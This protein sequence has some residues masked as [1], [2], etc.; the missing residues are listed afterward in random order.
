M[1]KRNDRDWS[2]RTQAGYICNK[3]IKSSDSLDLIHWKLGGMM[4]RKDHSGRWK[5]K[6]TCNLV[7]PP[8]TLP[9]IDAWLTCLPIHGFTARLCIGSLSLQH[10]ISTKGHLHFY[11]AIHHIR[12]RFALVCDWNKTSLFFLQQLTSWKV[13]QMGAQCHSWNIHF[14]QKTT[15]RQWNWQYFSIMFEG[16][17]RTDKKDLRYLVFS[18]FPPPIKKKSASK[19]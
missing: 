13:Y 18:Y 14:L 2:V 9:H 4:T 6:G 17:S 12:S 3:A 19:M 16:K 11:F 1:E 8:D 7:W 15:F 10:R 5:G